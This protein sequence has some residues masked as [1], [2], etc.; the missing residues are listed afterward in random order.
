MLN[1]GHTVRRMSKTSG[2]IMD[3]QICKGLRLPAE[4]VRKV[5]RFAK[6]EGSTF[7]QFIR[8]AVI[9]ELTSRAKEA[10]R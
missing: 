2:K 8:T 10:T 4:L 6:A 3:K 7:S 5:E 1:I 9:H